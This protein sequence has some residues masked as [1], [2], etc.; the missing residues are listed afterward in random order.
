MIDQYEQW[1]KDLPL[2]QGILKNNQFEGRK[3]LLEYGLPKK[4]QEPWRLTDLNKIKNLFKMPLASGKINSNKL[5]TKPK[6]T[7]RLILE[8][9][10]LKAISLPK[11][12]RILTAKEIEQH[13]KN[14]NDKISNTEN[15]SMAIN[16]ACSNN[17]IALKIND[18]EQCNFEIVIPSQ[19]KHLSSTRILLIIGKKA[20][21]NLLQ[22]AIGSNQSAISNLIEIHLNEGSEVNHGFIG[23][24]KNDDNLLAQLLINQSEK[25][26][27]SLTSV[28]YGWS[29][30]RIEPRVIQQQGKASTTIKGLQ[31]SSESQQLSTHS[32]VDFQGP[33][34]TLSQ[35]QKSVAT[36][37]SHC[38]FNGGI[39]V[40]QI[41]QRTNASQLSRNLL[42]SNKARIDTK[43]ELEIIA[44]DVKCAHGATVSQLQE[45]ELFYL[46]SRGVTINQATN[47]LLKG[48]CQ[49]IIDQLPLASGRWNLMQEMLKFLNK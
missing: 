17:I 44:D 9:I 2:P 8:N 29:I 22:I 47:L 37:Q 27:Y 28:Q 1:I 32:S 31:L 18:N 35:L 46:Q 39:N 30:S 15:W 40:P 10:E 45:D 3:S 16:N 19:I 43:P 36:N 13:L 38:I 25:S 41:A 48:Y 5:P 6:N 24:G 26:L 7:T 11:S 33:E 4:N 20:K 34:G 21:L 42:I 49:E 12:V 23:M 14:S